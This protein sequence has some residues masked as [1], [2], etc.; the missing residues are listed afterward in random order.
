M[1]KSRSKRKRPASPRIVSRY[2]KD[3]GPL[4]G[5]QMDVIRR[6]QPSGRMIVKERLF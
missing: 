4:F 3:G 1:R 2:A 5:K 6:L